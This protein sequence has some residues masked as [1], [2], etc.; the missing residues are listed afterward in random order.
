MQSQ[1]NLSYFTKHILIFQKKFVFIEKSH[2][3][4]L[5][6][7]SIYHFINDSYFDES[8]LFQSYIEYIVEYGDFENY[9][10]TDITK[11]SFSHMQLFKKLTDHYKEYILEL[12]G[13]YIITLI[14]K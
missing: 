2:Q 6:R 10:E 1:F 11:H 4:I 7:K 5:N 12:K 3:F 13:I 8:V 14:Y 9:N